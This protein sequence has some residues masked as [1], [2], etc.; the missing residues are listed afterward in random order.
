MS[1]ALQNWKTSLSGILSAVMAVCL[2][3][4]ATGSPLITPKV[5]MW[6]V[7]ILA[8]AKAIVGVIQKD[9]GTASAAVAQTKATLG[10][11]N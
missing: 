5:G 7:V 1:E 11:G 8:A 3:L 2:A 4:M 10:K 6:L 9:A